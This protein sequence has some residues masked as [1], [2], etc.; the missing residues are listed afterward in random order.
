MESPKNEGERLPVEGTSDLSARLGALLPDDFSKSKDWES[1]TA[2]DRIEWLKL[3][4]GSYRTEIERLEI[5]LLEIL[6]QLG[7][8]QDQCERYRN[9]LVEITDL[10]GR[11]SDLVDAQR[12]AYAA[13]DRA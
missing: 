1:G 10:S 2:L 12:I 3:F 5:Q 13:L 4:N 11:K 7:Q 6:E 9:A 8:K